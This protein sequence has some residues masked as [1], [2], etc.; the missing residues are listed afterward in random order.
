[1]TLAEALAA[2]I[3]ATD[4]D[5]ITPQAL[6]YARIGVLDTLAVGIAGAGEEAVSIAQRVTGAA[7]GPALLWGSD[8]RVGAL[9]AAFINGI[10]ANVLDFDDCTDNLG[11]H[12]SSPVLPALIAL[13]EERGAS[14]RDVI[15]AYV[16]GFETETCIGRGV[17]FHHYEKGWHPTATLGVFG[18]AAACARLMK[19]N[20]EQTTRALALC[21]SLAAGVKSNLGSMAKPMH[22]GH[23]SR[24]GL[25]AARHAAEGV[26]GNADALEHHH[27]FLEL[28]NGAGTYDIGRILAKWGTP[29]DIEMPGIAIKQYPCC[30]STQA[31]VDVMLQLTREHG[32]EAGKVARVDARIA[33]RRLAH[34]DRPS[35]RSALD[36]KLSAQYVLARALVNREV[37][38]PHFEGDSYRDPAIQPAMTLMHVVPLDAQ[39]LAREGDSYADVVVTLHDGRTFE[40][41]I[42]RPVGHH[43]GVPL[44]AALHRRKFE[45]CVHRHLGRQQMDDFYGAVQSLENIR[46]VRELTAHIVVAASRP[47][48]R[49]AG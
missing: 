15:T 48:A 9:D 37:N 33:A 17:N 43:A 27:G 40:G 38:L 7:G 47:A 22:I 4:F 39:T 30:L 3:A 19:L 6:H 28:F 8:Q 32:L 13:A 2:R 16:A 41:S 26:T 36:A 1:M 31:A 20:A 18:A 42:E 14:G 49:A 45:G 34:T 44:A 24:N 10:A 23:S 12:P 21:A 46:D 29:W 5:A 25:L 35:P 11:G